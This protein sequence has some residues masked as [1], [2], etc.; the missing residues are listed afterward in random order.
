MAF[1]ND[2][3]KKISQ[4]SQDVVKKTKDSSEIY[5]L[6]GM[7]SEE[8]RKINSIYQQLGKL[9]YELHKDSYE[10]SFEAMVLQINDCEN[11]KIQCLEQI[12][13]IKGIKKCPQCGSEIPYTAK[14]CNS[15][16]SQLEVEKADIPQ[17]TIS[18][19][20][21]CKNCNNVI[22]ENSAF[23]ENC[24]TPVT[25]NE[26]DL[27][28]PTEPVHSENKKCSNCGEEIGDAAFCPNC[29]TKVE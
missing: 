3:S 20:I 24:G 16:G 4:T 15:C 18:N 29:G 21:T 22:G 12:D 28:S 6:E 19:V 5:R 23:C 1:L 13:K 8:D 14:F 25:A 10:I 17:E 7:I 11:R 2:L 27:E 9:Y 26:G